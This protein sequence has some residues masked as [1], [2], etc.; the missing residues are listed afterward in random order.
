VF[1]NVYAGHTQHNLK[2]YTFFAPDDSPM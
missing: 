2:Y 1:K